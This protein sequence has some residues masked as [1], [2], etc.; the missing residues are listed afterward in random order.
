MFLHVFLFRWKPG[1]TEAQKARVAPA[2]QAFQGVIPGLLETSTGNN[3]SPRGQDYTFGGVMKFT[4]RQAFEA[5]FD[6]PAHVELISW[7]MPLIDPVE[8]DF[9]V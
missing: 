2:V 7:L 4:D 5:Y 1:V 8:L 6:H 3:T 9:E